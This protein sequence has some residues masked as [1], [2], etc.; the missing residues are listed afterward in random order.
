M[1]DTFRWYVQYTDLQKRF[2]S[3]LTTPYVHVQFGYGLP[4]I[5]HWSNSSLR[6]A[7]TP[8]ETGAE[9]SLPPWNVLRT[10]LLCISTLKLLLDAGAQIKS[11]SALTVAAKQGRT[12]VVA[13]LLD[14]GGGPAAADVVDIIDEILD[15]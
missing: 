1:Y 12:D 7:P 5:P 9:T 6:V 13:F 4:T 2:F 15:K 11:R 8:T 3:K 14:R 10:H